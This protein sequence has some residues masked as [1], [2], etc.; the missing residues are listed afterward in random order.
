MNFK[1]WIEEYKDVFGF[2]VDCKIKEII[3][4]DDKPI[5][6][7]KVNEMMD[8]LCQQQLSTLESYQ[9]FSN[10]C[11]WGTNVGSIK[12]AV[13]S[14]FTVFIER[15]IKDLEGNSK[16]I[17]KKVFKIN[18]DE[19]KGYE[20]NVADAIF[21][22]V[23]KVSKEGLD[24]PNKKYDILYDLIETIV[25]DFKEKGHKFF[26]YQGIKKINENNYILQFAVRG[27]GLGVLVKK[28]SESRVNEVIIDVSFNEKTGLL[29]VIE[30]T[31]QT[32]D[33]GLS[34]DLA[35]SFFEGFYTPTQ[36][37]QEITDTIMTSLIYF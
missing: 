13:G 10:E 18:T 25:D 9:K 11:Q 21:E 20:S 34:W 30:T 4:L 24:S 6:P 1:L 37:N 29:H 16:W 15:L 22:E 5:K 8:R 26:V 3:P 2:D 31:V 35:P 23:V 17:T 12:V 27:S 33:E 32:S 14:K 36:N 7:F 19:F 28:K